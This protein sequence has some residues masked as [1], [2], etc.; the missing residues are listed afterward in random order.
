MITADSPFR[1]GVYIC[2]CGTNIASAIDPQELCEFAQ[3]LPGV[4]IARTYKYLCSDPGQDMIKRDI[5]Q[6]QC[7]RIVIAACSPL[8]HEK[9][10]RGAVEEAGINPF[11]VQMEANNLIIQV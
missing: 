9:T 7:D 8:L 5:V 10:F 4:A 6:H 3:G 11:L 2:H 1:T